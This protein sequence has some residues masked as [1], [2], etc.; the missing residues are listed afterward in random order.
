MPLAV[1]LKVAH[2]FV[3]DVNNGLCLSKR[4]GE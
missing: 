2:S 4:L 3:S 1:S